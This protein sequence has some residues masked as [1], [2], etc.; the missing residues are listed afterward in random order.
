VCI[1]V[2]VSASSI[3]LISPENSFVFGLSTPKRRIVR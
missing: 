3:G 1:V 2:Y